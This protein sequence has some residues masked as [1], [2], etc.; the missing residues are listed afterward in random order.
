MGDES[1]K[2]KRGCLCMLSI[3]LFIAGVMI[4]ASLIFLNSSQAIMT[5][6]VK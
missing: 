1:M 2:K 4:F 3:L 5:G 6:N